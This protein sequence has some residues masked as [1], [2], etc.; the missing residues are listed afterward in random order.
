LGHVMRRI[1]RN[2]A[3]MRKPLFVNVHVLFLRASCLVCGDTHARAPLYKIGLMLCVRVCH[4]GRKGGRAHAS[5][6][7]ALSGE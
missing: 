7:R 3:G 1:W 6:P 4:P 5:H 2:D